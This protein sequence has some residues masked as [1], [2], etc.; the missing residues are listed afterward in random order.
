[1]KK[2]LIIVFSLTA[3]E[4]A[5]QI[6]CPECETVII[7]IDNAR[8]IEISTPEPIRKAR[9]RRKTIIIISATAV[10]SSAITAAVTI[11]KNVYGCDNK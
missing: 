11:T 7:H 10:V 4:P 9:E 3:M 1:M 2:T 8:D 5:K 6:K